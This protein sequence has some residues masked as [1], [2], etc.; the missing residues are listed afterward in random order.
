MNL[1]TFED[2]LAEA[3][4]RSTNIVTAIMQTVNGAIG[5]GENIK[6]REIENHGAP[7]LVYSRPSCYR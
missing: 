2:T 5:H 3:H 4:L 7:P 1:A 6:K